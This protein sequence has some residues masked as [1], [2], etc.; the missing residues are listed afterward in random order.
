MRLKEMSLRKPYRLGK[1]SLT[2]LPCQ[3][4]LF[5]GELVALCVQCYLQQS[6]L[7]ERGAGTA[8]WPPAGLLWALQSSSCTAD[9]T[10]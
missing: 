9:A 2:L 10:G 4:F 6:W 7:G 3:L 8:S 1:Q 5:R